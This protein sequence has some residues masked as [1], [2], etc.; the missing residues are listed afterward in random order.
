MK[1]PLSSRLLFL[2]LAL[3]QG[4]GAHMADYFSAT[5]IFN[6]RW[7]P[8]AKFHGGQTLSMSIMLG[9]MSVLFAW[10]KTSDKKT[11]VYAAAGFSRPTAF[12]LAFRGTRI[13]KSDLSPSSD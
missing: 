3:Q 4:V 5:H 9:V 8:H 7:P 13:L 2:L 1:M 12:C 11:T 10:R 6:A